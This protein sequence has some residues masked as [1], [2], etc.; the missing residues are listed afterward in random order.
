MPLDPFTDQSFLYR[1]L[2]DHSFALYST[3][4]SKVDHGG[5]FGPW[6]MVAAG[7][8]DLCLDA[9]DYSSECC[10]INLNQEEPPD[11]VH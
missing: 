5:V 3:R 8:A 11:P 6:M 4:P 7:H 10:A 2:S 9:G 1:R